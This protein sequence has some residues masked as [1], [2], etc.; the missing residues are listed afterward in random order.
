MI[1][2]SSSEF[3]QLIWNVANFERN[4][5]GKQYIW[6]RCRFDVLVQACPRLQPVVGGNIE[7]TII[8]LDIISFLQCLYFTLHVL[9]FKFVSVK[10]PFPFM[11]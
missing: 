1:K 9:P 4:L 3:P 7:A 11:Y 2:F 10:G 8:N 6:S 5:C